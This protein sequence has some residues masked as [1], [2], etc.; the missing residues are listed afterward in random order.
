MPSQFTLTTEC[1]RRSMFRPARST[2][3]VGG[4]TTLKSCNV[5]SGN[6]KQELDND[7]NRCHQCSWSD[8]SGAKCAGLLV[9]TVRALY[10]P[11]SRCNVNLQLWLIDTTSRCA[12]S[13]RHKDRW[14]ITKQ[15][16]IVMLTHGS[17]SDSMQDKQVNYISVLGLIIV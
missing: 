11:G 8:V 10:R 13:A 14:L 4:K 9:E 7:I 5:D 17:H 6:D 16:I 3:D 1:I 2:D 12:S 15:T